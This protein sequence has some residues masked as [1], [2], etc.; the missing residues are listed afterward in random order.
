MS[1]DRRS[2]L[3]VGGLLGG[4]LG[5]GKLLD[6]EA[7]ANPTADRV[8]SLPVLDRVKIEP[9]EDVLIR[10]QRE[11]VR[12]MNKPIEQRRWG[13]V[14]DTRKCVGCHSCNVGC[15][16]E[17][18]LPPGVVYRP[19]IDLEVGRYPNVGRKFLP[20]PCM[21]CDNPPCVPVCPVNATWKRADGVV[22]IDYNV[23]IGCRYCITACPY[24]ARTFDFGQNWA[25]NAASGRDGGLALETGRKYEQEP[26]FE[27]GTNWHRGEGVI[28]KSPVGNARK[29][30]FCV[31]RLEHRQLPMC[32]TTCIGR[33]TL[34]GDLNDQGALVSQQVIRNNAVSLKAELGTAPK[35]IYLI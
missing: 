8:A 17:N 13:M 1:M 27:Y 2:I 31:H 11:L 33:A 22:V 19:V 14:I 23:C 6:I 30:T 29:C 5:A 3:K 25:S 34:F 26:S 7:L 21:Q 18:K 20:R 12:A 4:A 16:M 15:I 10:M 24:Q 35:V 9:G 28:P 32:V